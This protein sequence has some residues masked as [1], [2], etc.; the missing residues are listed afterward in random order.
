METRG[1]W[2]CCR[3]A[4]WKACTKT[5]NLRVSSPQGKCGWFEVK[6]PGSPGLFA[7]AQSRE[8]ESTHGKK[9]QADSQI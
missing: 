9:G 4:V 1:C 5:G 6:R 2:E 8:D 7:A 3:E